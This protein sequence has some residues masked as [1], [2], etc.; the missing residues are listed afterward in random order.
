MACF[1]ARR[2]FQAAL[3]KSVNLLVYGQERLGI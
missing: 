3:L 1:V 2:D